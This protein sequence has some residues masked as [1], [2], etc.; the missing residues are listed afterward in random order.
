MADSRIAGLPAPSGALTK[1][2][3]LVLDNGTD[4]SAVQAS[5]RLV[6][7]TWLGGLTGEGD[8]TL[9][10]RL[11]DKVHL[12]DF[13]VTTA[14]TAAAVT[15]ALTNA[16]AYS[17][18]GVVAVPPGT[19]LLNSVTVAAGKLLDIEP[20]G[21]LSVQAGQTLTNDGRII[22]TGTGIG[23]PGTI[24]GTGVVID[25]SV[26][27]SSSGGLTPTP[28]KTAAYTAV[29]NDL[30]RTDTSAGAVTV[31]LPSAPADGTII[32]ILDTAN[33][34]AT[35]NLTI[36]RN[37]K[38]ISGAAA[39]RV[40]SSAGAYY[41]LVYSAAQNDW[42]ITQQPASTVAASFTET[43]AWTGSGTG[44][45]GRSTK[46]RAEDQGVDVLA[47]GADPTAVA[48]STAA[49]QAA[50][51]YAAGVGKRLWF[52]TGI[53]KVTNQINVTCRNVEGETPALSGGANNG[54]VLVWQPAAVTDMK[55][56]LNLSGA[57]GAAVRN[58][59]VS[60]PVG[61]TA[62]SITTWVTWGSLPSYSAITAGVAAFATSGQGKLSFDNCGSVN[63][64]V[65]WYLNNTDG[66]VTLKDCRSNYGNLIGL[67]CKTNSE[68]YF[69]YGG[70]MSGALCS[71]AFG[72]T[73]Y[74]GHYGGF[75]ATFLRW[76]SYG[77]PYA[78]Y[79]FRDYTSDTS[80]IQT[81]TGFYGQFIGCTFEE[82]AEC[83]IKTLPNAKN[84]LYL[85]KSLGDFSTSGSSYRLPTGVI[86]AASQQG[87]WF[88]LGQVGSLISV[89]WTDFSGAAAFPVSTTNSSP[90]TVRGDFSW[91]NTPLDGATLAAL[92]DAY[93][94]T[95]RNNVMRVQPATFADP[96]AAS[97]ADLC[98]Y[99]DVAPR[100]SLVNNPEKFGSTLGTSDNGSTT[101][102]GNWTKASGGGTAPKVT[103]NSLS[104]WGATL[105]GVPVPLHMI[106][107]L[108]ENPNVVALQ[109]DVNGAGYYC[110]LNFLQ[111]P[112]TTKRLVTLSLWW[113]GTAGIRARINNGLGYFTYDNQVGTN[114]AVWTK[115]LG[116]GQRVG[117]QAGSDNTY[118]QVGISVP[119]GNGPVYFAGLM[120]G[121]DEN[122][123]Y[124]PYAGPAL[125][126]K[127]HLIGHTTATTAPSAGGAGALPATPAGYVTVNINGTDRKLPYY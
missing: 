127:A 119:S 47:F 123:V 1:A 101:G 98:T 91:L 57:D 20:G 54:V 120:V 110:T 39:N 61:Y 111:Q 108:G 56:C 114:G 87:Y 69:L 121:F 8:R 115:F 22:H 68:D 117:D 46:A 19:Y 107:E 113:Y 76:H 7:D 5:A 102:G 72:D 17:P 63:C 32:G 92:R 64:K 14:S 83:C 43:T 90:R 125:Q 6:S 36:G 21:V 84:Q 77:S 12:T 60:G 105:S 44:A 2:H 118:W 28:I 106:Q 10:A 86:A 65:G 95:G 15:T 23:G 26:T 29:A 34:W 109:Q 81:V 51:D 74:V 100:A 11:G 93:T 30:V 38:T 50:Q 97:K 73:L 103:I 89:G 42:D 67:Y 104:G 35:N 59:F 41:Q 82:V 9:G 66:H 27:G 79:Q 3:H 49:I 75:G 124:N 37:G 48:D 126:A 112:L 94:A 78:V 55:A 80:G 85:S 52:P 31:T 96:Q 33:S 16:L 18:T 13:G 71:I 99:R 53:Y 4:A 116:V 40:L 24:A 88:D 70:G 45:V 25:L 122:D 58:I 62:A